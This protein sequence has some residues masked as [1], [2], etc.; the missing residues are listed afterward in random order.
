M[1]LFKS[2]IA[3]FIG[4]CYYETYPANDLINNALAIL[5]RD[6]ETNKNAIMELYYAICDANGY[7]YDANAAELYKHGIDVPKR[8]INDTLNEYIKKN[9]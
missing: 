7:F 8:C 4:K 6:F 2:F 9:K 3:M 5:L 1:K